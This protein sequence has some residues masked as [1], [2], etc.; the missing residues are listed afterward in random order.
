[1]PLH[2]CSWEYLEEGGGREGKEKRRKKM[3]KTESRK[4]RNTM[5]QKKEKEWGNYLIRN[6]HN[7]SCK[8]IIIMCLKFGRKRSSVYFTTFIII[9]NNASMIINYYFLHP[10]G[11]RIDF[12]MQQRKFPKK[13]N[14]IKSKQEHIKRANMIIL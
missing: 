9:S 1:M 2:L 8:F 11:R 14:K 12:D 4:K 5:K 10:K 13:K 6:L 3:E 7:R